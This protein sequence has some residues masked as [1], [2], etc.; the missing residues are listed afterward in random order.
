MTRM[1]GFG[2]Y[3]IFFNHSFR[4][5]S[6]HPF[7][8]IL[9]I[10]C[11]ALGI[12]NFIAIQLIN[13]SALESFRAS[14]DL[15]GGKANLEI[16]AESAPFDEQIL[17]KVVSD[18]DVLV[19]TPILEQV[20]MLE[21]HPGEYLDIVGV[22]FLTNRPVRSFEL[23]ST[24]NNK[25]DIIDFLKDPQAVGLNKKLAQRL[26][27]KRGDRLKLRTPEGIVE[28][29]VHSFLELE[30][31][32]IGSD[33]HMAVMDI[34][35]AQELFHKVGQLSRISCLV[36][37]K[38]DRMEFIRSLQE[39]LPPTVIVQTP[40]KRNMKIEKMLGSFQLNLTALSLI[41]LFVGMFIIYNTVLV[42]VV[43]RR[44]EIALLRCLCLGSKSIIAACLGESLIVSIIGIVLGI[45]VGYVVASKLVGWVS[46][47]LTSL[48]LLSSIEKIFISPYH[49]ALAF[50]VGMAASGVASFFPSIEASKI[51]PVQA[52]SPATLED[53]V[54]RFGPFWFLCV[55]GFILLALILSFL[56]LM[57]G[58]PVL[59][60]GAA[61]FLLLA[62]SFVSPFVCKIVVQLIKP[63]QVT[64][65]L[66][67]SHFR[68]SIHRNALTISALLTAL[69]MVISVSVMIKSFRYTVDGWL[70]QSVRA[71]LFVTTAANLASG[72]HQVL[73]SAA[74][75][76][77]KSDN[78]IEAVDRYYE[79]RSEFRNSPIKISA[80]C[81][82]VAA[83]RNNLEFRTGKAEKL[84]RE[85]VGSNRV[86]INESLSRKFKLKEKDI[87]SLKTDKGRVDFEI[88]GIFKD[89]T[90]EFGLVLMDWQ[91][92]NKYWSQTGSNSLA[93]YLKDSRQAEEIK[94]ELDQK[95]QLLG[96]YI[97]YSNAQLRNEIFRIFDQTF[98]ITQ[99]LKITSLLIS[100]AGIFFNLLILS[101]ERN[102]EIAILRSVGAP[103]QVVYALVLGESGLVGLISSLLGLIAGLA[104]A[105]VL[106]YVIN[107]SFFG[108]TID[109][110]TPWSTLLWLPLMVIFIS[111][112]ASI[113]PAFQLGKA[114]ISQNLRVE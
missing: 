73:S 109:W 18:P 92:M 77:I 78:R 39:K 17:S 25:E 41:S 6:Q 86:F 89:Y 37:K 81:F 114:N 93:L 107:R 35:N 47:S 12:A 68:R 16:A 55:I 61:L 84:L 54:H 50:I 53:K 31:G 27:I 57:G 108:W 19:A 106:T 10:F 29:K 69:A 48:Y 112:L 60:F 8:L 38:K 76:L 11:I 42:G 59:S 52:F 111:L 2:L 102:R 23:S 13:H 66:I 56:S 15:V 30:S 28:L 26:G 65:K 87:I 91:T 70:K 67:L 100:A 36:S 63:K 83:G 3:K 44:S 97:V 7:L 99:L 94:K 43:R 113:L 72:I 1:K 82:S 9:N 101:S 105:V 5:F 4:Y 103:R 51:V 40:E 80:I 90:T 20:C 71:D 46:S 64:F 110:S 22:D 75:E 32:A 104:L 79:F 85:A 49:L 58:L 21:N 34:S 45:P 33:E 98:S 24:V 62:F 88:F 14:I 95:L 96:D 74:E